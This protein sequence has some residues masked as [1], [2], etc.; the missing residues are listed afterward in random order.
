MTLIGALA[1]VA[2]VG[3]GLAATARLHL[4]HADGFSWI[5]TGAIGF[6]LFFVGGTTYFGAVL[7]DIYPAGATSFAS[8]VGVLAL[9]IAHR[10]ARC[11]AWAR[12]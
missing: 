10:F 1:L 5:I 4:T 6:G 7:F 11:T 12:P 2:V 9:L 8:S 3:F